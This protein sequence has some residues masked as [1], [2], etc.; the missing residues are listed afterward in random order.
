MFMQSNIYLVSHGKVYSIRSGSLLNIP[1]RVAANSEATGPRVHSG[2]VKSLVLF[3]QPYFGKP[4]RNI[5]VAN[6]RG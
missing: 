2:S 3:S 1:L 6:D 4:L 5:C